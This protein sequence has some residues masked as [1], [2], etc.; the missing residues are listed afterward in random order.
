MDRKAWIV[1]VSCLLVFF[2]HGK[3]IDLIWP[4]RAVPVPQ[5]AQETVSG[6]NGSSQETPSAGNPSPSSS[7]Q[8]QAGKTDIPT[9]PTPAGPQLSAVEEVTF[10]EGIIQ[11]KLVTLRNP[12]IEATLTSWGGGVKEVKLLRH[13]RIH[14]EPLIINEGNEEPI[15]NVTGVSLGSETIVGYRVIESDSTHAVFE[16]D[17]ANGGTLRREYRL[18]NDYEILL[19]QTLKNPLAE[20]IAFDP[21]RMQVGL[22]EPI[23]GSS[24]ERRHL[25][26]SW[27]NL[28]NAYKM[29]NVTEFDNSFFGL[30][31]G[32]KAIYS[33][34]GERLAWVACQN[35]FFASIIN[36]GDQAATDVR[37]TR[38][39]L[40]DF[41]EEKNERVPD[42]MLVT[43][44]IPG[45]KAEAKGEA[46]QSFSL[47]AGPKE[48]KRLEALNHGE[49]KVLEFGWMYFISVLLLRALQFIHSTMEG[50]GLV[51]SWG[52]AIIIMTILIKS[53]L[54]IPQTKANLS[55]KKMQVVSKPMK[56]LQ[57]KYKDNP[58][59]LNE[60]MMALYK[61]YGVN[62]VAG[63]LPMFLQ[64]P[65]FLGFY[66]MLMG[67][68]ELR[69]ES[70]F[71]VKDLAQP[72][73]VGNL[74]LPLL[75][76]IPINPMPLLMAG[77]MLWSFQITPQPQGVDNPAYK[78]TKFMPLIFLLICYNYAAALSLY[79]TVQSL[80]S[81]V[82]MYYNSKVQLPTLED[83]EKKAETKAKA[84]SDMQSRFGQDPK[85]KKFGKGPRNQ[86]RKRK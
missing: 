28:D 26:V 54:W 82:Q 4:P 85:S 47:Y 23:Y 21:Y 57:E 68:I 67:A 19:E 13:D 43:A 34:E 39:R 14:E 37:G 44:A 36:M 30:S 22:A 60:E 64:I 7:L 75:G 42:G 12:F 69:H 16:R 58:T 15:F 63:C 72:D 41:R 48:L 86:K 6:S 56:E 46:R 79:W 33:P 5:S 31:Q 45:M 27:S 40:P 24:S 80:L 65:I 76:I 8:E 61:K 52:W 38:K 59:K 29:H 49:T 17:L 1:I 50:W 78:V 20:K 84:K 53:A 83:L 35:Q 3:V 71:W 25:G 62:P 2:F 11:E 74:P 66:Y 32:K 18:N 55:M 70:F 51:D 73:T 77:T 9:V 10:E 81:I